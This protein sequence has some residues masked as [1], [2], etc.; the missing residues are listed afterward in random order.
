M[1][2]GRKFRTSEGKRIIARKNKEDGDVVN[3]RT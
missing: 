1:N 2:D 3:E